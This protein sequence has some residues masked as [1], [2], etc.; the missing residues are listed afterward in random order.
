MQPEILAEI[1]ALH[2]LRCFY[3]EQRKRSHLALGSFLRRELGWS[4]ALPEAERK[5]IAKQ[6]AQMV[7]DVEGEWCDVIAE[8]LASAEPFAKREEA[9]L[10]AMTKLA[11]G[12]PVWQ[13]FGEPIRGFGAGSLAVILA[14]AGDLS[15]YA[16][17]GKL[18]KR[19]GIAVMGEVRQGGLKKGASKDAWIEHGYSAVRRSRMW[20]VGAALIKGN[21][22]GP[23]RAIY[24]DQKQKYIARGW[25]KLHAHRAAQRYM[26]KRLLRNLWQAWRQTTEA[27]KPIGRLSAADLH[28]GVPC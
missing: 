17:P 14:E 9:S 4:L 20:N 1:R 21:R 15:G 11:E 25:T 10:K 6:A 28:T 2:R 27:V 19:M 13:R 26:E 23:Y 3:M 12:L 24:L 22:D 5:K 8:V 16:N 7:A 18:W